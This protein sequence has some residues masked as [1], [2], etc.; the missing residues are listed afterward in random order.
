MTHNLLELR[1]EDLL[2]SHREVS[3]KTVG[4]YIMRYAQGEI[5]EPVTVTF[6]VHTGKYILDDGHH[7]IVAAYFLK[8]PSIL[9]KIEP[10]YLYE[11]EGNELNTGHFFNIRH[12]IMS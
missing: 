3:K 10:C 11:C 6:C 7:R 12:V 8:K 9:A 4:K 5:V 1:I 2:L